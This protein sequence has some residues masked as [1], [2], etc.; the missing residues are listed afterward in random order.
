LNQMNIEIDNS[1]ESIIIYIGL[2]KSRVCVAQ[3]KNK[4]LKN[5]VIESIDLFQSSG[6]ESGIE[7]HQI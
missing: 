2:L 7:Y 6:C 1:P 3:S 5:G 4:T